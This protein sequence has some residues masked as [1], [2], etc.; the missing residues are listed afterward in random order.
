[1]KA[2]LLNWMG[3]VVLCV[4]LMSAHQVLS[5]TEKKTG[6]VYMQMRNMLLVHMYD[7]LPNNS[8]L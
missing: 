3:F 8:T 7:P 2:K 6:N 5:L 1:M 4:R